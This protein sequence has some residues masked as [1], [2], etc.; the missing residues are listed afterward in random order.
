M[1][2]CGDPL[3]EGYMNLWPVITR[4]SHD[5]FPSCVQGSEIHVDRKLSCMVVFLGKC[6]WFHWDARH[7]HHCYSPQWKSAGWNPWPL[8]LVDYEIAPWKSILFFKSTSHNGI[9]N[10]TFWKNIWQLVAILTLCNL[11]IYKD[12][13]NLPPNAMDLWFW[14]AWHLCKATQHCTT[15]HQSIDT[16][17]C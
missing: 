5:L 3:V 1:F 6:S 8:L 2:R 13:L 16:R 10:R 7:H 12:L 14:D 4:I 15:T 17:M 9:L 11:T